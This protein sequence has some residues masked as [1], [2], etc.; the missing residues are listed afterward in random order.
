M[1]GG[2]R[3][4]M[5]MVVDYAKKRNQFGR[6]IGSFQ[7]I[8]HHCADILTYLETSEF[9]TWQAAW[10]IS[11]GR[12]YEKEAAMAKAWVSDSCRKL[13]ALG[14]QVMGGMGFMEEFD[15]H[16]YLRQ[17]KA[18]ELAFGDAVFHRELVAQELGL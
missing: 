18:S 5:E 2:G 15:L 14:H 3:K 13:V 11:E 8:Q 12:S 16:L 6:P 4:V 17:A 10:R 9:M 7:A 1:I